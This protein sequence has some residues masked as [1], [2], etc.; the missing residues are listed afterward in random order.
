MCDFN[1][2]LM[3]SAART[4][5]SGDSNLTPYGYGRKK[6]E[7][8][9]KAVGDGKAPHGATSSN[10]PLQ[11]GLDFTAVSKKR[12]AMLSM[13][14]AS[15]SAAEGRG[16][17]LPGGHPGGGEASSAA[18]S[19]QVLQGVME[20][21]KKAERVALAAGGDDAALL[22]GF[23]WRRAQMEHWRRTAAPVAAVVD[24]A[25][26][27]HALPRTKTEEQLDAEEASRPGSFP[28]GA[29]HGFR[30]HCER[31]TTRQALR[32]RPVDVKAALVSEPIWEAVAA[33]RPEGPQPAAPSAQLPSL[34]SEGPKQL[35][36]RGATPVNAAEK[37]VG[38]QLFA[39]MDD[40][41]DDLLA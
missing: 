34:P 41:V 1:D 21:L 19:L 28:W 30:V 22:S 18:K 26:S 5:H 11:Q 35:A 39:G 29:V 15:L 6:G 27:F 20:H 24:E 16:D 4:E 7:K 13:Q 10:L 8:G 31:R 38:L 33:I 14:A 17:L 2:L 37:Q 25:V 12:E 32:W 23:A 36:G 9:G 3:E 40:N